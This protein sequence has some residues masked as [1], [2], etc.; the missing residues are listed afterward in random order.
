MLD[1]PYLDDMEVVEN[2]LHYLSKEYPMKATFTLTPAESRRLIAKA[3]VQMPEVKAALEK[4]YVILAGGTTNAFIYQELLGRS[5]EPARHTAGT[6]TN[7]VLCVTNVAD[8]APFPTILYKGQVVDK[9]IR[10]ALDDFHRETVIIKGANAVDPEG[11]VGIITSGFDGGTVAATIGTVSSQGLKY[12][13]PVG[14]EKLIPSVKDAVQVTGAKTLD[15]C[16]GSD[17]GMYCLVNALVVTEIQALKLLCDVEARQVAAGGIGGCEGAVVL[18][19]MGAEPAVRAAIA[20][21]ESIKGEPAIA[22]LK[23]TCSTCRYVPVCRD[24]RRGL[25]GVAAGLK[26]DMSCIEVRDVLSGTGDSRTAGRREPCPR[27][28]TAGCPGPGAGDSPA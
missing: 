19:I 8:R 1:I 15:Y 7:G 24:A 12:I 26:D 21:I 4:A 10:Q 23:G 2:S 27:A 25:A 16:I 13:V 6:V 22:G 28:R 20:L 5:V 18:V 11:N 3:V 9:T 14:L 17:F